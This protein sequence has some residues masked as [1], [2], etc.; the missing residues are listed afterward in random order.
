MK[1]NQIK[2]EAGRAIPINPLSAIEYHEWPQYH[3]FESW[4]LT[5]PKI[6][7]AAPDRVYNVDE[8]EPVVWQFKELDEI[9]WTSENINAYKMHSDFTSYTKYA[10]EINENY[11][12]RQWLELKPAG[13]SE[14]YSHGIHEYKGDEFPSFVGQK[15]EVFDDNS[16]ENAPCYKIRFVGSNEILDNMD[17]SDIDWLEQPDKV[18]E[19]KQAGVIKWEYFNPEFKEWQATG[20]ICLAHYKGYQVRKVT[21]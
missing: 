2:V 5:L 10:K 19:E 3:D 21:E 17:D 12:T 1:Y 14:D 4:L 16:N 9:E 15:I 8:F 20:N 11:E 13:E 7:T 6:H 18:G